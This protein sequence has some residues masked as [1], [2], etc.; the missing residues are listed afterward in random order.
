[1]NLRKN[2]TEVNGIVVP[3]INISAIKLCTI[4]TVYSMAYADKISISENYLRYMMTLIGVN[5]VTK[6]KTFSFYVMD[7]NH[8]PALELWRDYLQGTLQTTIKIVK[9]WI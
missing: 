2:L 5:G 8:L 4:D 1:M 7:S 9:L 3:T 6:P